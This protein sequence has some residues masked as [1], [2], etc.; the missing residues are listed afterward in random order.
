MLNKPRLTPEQKERMHC[1][2]R[3]QSTT[4]D[5][6]RPKQRKMSFCRVCFWSLPQDMRRALYRK[7]G[8]GYEAA[9]RAACSHLQGDE[10]EKI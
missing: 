2:D 6:G 9:Y 7:I 5:C 1:V 10:E 4:C 8:E 3:L